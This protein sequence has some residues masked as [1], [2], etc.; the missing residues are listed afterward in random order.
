MIII[1][2][3]TAVIPEVS[4]VIIWVTTSVMEVLIPLAAPSIV[5]LVFTILKHSC[6]GLDRFDLSPLT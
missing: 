3:I 4:V 2:K 5:A 6:H 1:I